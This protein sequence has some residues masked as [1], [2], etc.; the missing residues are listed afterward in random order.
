MTAISNS[1]ATFLKTVPA[2]NQAFEAEGETEFLDI[3]WTQAHQRAAQRVHQARRHAGDAPAFGEQRRTFA[4]RGMGG[5]GS[6]GRDGGER[7]TE[8]VVQF[9]C[10]TPPLLV[11]H[12]DQ[13]SRQ[14]VAVGESGLQPLRQRVE[15]IGD[16]R[17]FREVKTG[18]ARREIVRR[19][20]LQ[21]CPDGLRRPQRA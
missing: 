1:G 21:P 15:D 8:F 6:L 16:R 3:R 9:A 4:L 19:K 13:L 11:L 10:E 12:L 20:P 5:G 14:H 17:Q 7:L 2:R 18:Q